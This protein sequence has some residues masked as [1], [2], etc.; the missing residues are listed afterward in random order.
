MMWG[1]IETATIDSL[2]RKFKRMKAELDEG[3]LRHWA[4]CEALEIGHGGVKAVAQATGLGER[5][6]RRG[7]QEIRQATPPVPHCGRRTR[8][9]GGGVKR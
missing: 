9:P 7:C 1:M 2:G 6:I 5:T 4:A 8:R 3:G